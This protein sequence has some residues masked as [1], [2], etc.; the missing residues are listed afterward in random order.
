MKTRIISLILVLVMAVLALAGCAYN[1]AA[2]DM[3]KYVTL[4]E[5]NFKKK[6]QELK[7]DDADFGTDETKR[8]DKVWDTIYTSLATEFKGN[9]KVTLGK[10]GAYDTFFY[11]YY[12]TY[13][14]DG[15]E[16]TVFSKKMNTSSP[17][18]FQLG[19]SSLEGLNKL[20]A[21][22]VK[23]LELTK[24]N[25]YTVDTSSATKAALGNMVAVSYKEVYNEPDGKGG[26]SKTT[27]TVT[28][29]IVTL[30]SALPAQGVEPTILDKLVG[31]NVGGEKKS[32][33]IYRDINGDGTIDK[34]GDDAEKVEYTSVQV[35]WVIKSGVNEHG[36][37]GITV[38]DKTYTTT[39]TET[40]VLG[41]SRDLKDEELTYHIFPIGFI[42]VA[43]GKSDITAK[44]ILEHLIG[45]SIKAPN[46]VNG[47]GVIDE[48]KDT[49]E[50]GKIDDDEVSEEYAGSLDVF[51][52]KDYKKDGKKISE[53]VKELVDF[54]TK[55]SEAETELT[56]KQTAYDKAKETVDNK[57]ASGG[58]P[59]EEQNKA[60]E[61]AETNLNTAKGA[62]EKAEKDVATGIE[63][64]LG[65]TKEGDE[66]GIGATIVEQYQ[67]SVYEGLE[68][69]YK[70]AIK[71]NLAKAVYALLTDKEITSFAK[72]ENGMWILPRDAVNQ[73]YDR[74]LNNYKYTFYEGD[75]NST[76]TNYN[77]YNGDLYKFLKEDKK[78]LNLGQDA[79]TQQVYDAI[80]VQAETAVKDTILV[81]RLAQ[82]YGD[83]VKVTQ[84]DVDE[85]KRSYNY[86]ILQYSLGY[87][88]N[89]DSSYY[90]PALQLNKVLNYILEENEE[91]DKNELDYVRVQ[92]SFN[93][94][95]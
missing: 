21:D 65:C 64:I 23:D 94:K 48:D 19:L 66:K 88:T 56:E 11:C 91:T 63:K 8:W 78:G 37:S 70:K 74:I 18:S 7:I 84:E 83:E 55:L 27:N 4:D 75:Y 34:E 76:T 69:D 77:K 86:L 26:S 57:T 43:D 50:N 38:S 25:V 12:A 35:D 59:T 62:K 73:A 60:L 40:D 87:G 31:L 54:Y 20:I 42:K 92:Y 22:K 2:D 10:P 17:S 44:V 16:I 58:T 30:P 13:V 15:K 41:K 46:D 67:E 32:F 6:L 85:F 72:G 53:L 45:S 1:Y 29:M 52:D 82:M 36:E 93:E 3:S 68:N 89:V 33:D 28:N 51:H 90:M 49:N 80:G 81:Y 47:N 39:T 79:T 71:E 95:K 24:D 61:T 5:E 14:K 9:D